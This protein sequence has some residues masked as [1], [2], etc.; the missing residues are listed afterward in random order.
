MSKKRS[1]LLYFDNFRRV[2]DLPDEQLGILLR[3]LME[4]GEKEANGE[5]G[6]TGLRDRYPELCEK[7]Q[8]A[9]SFMADTIRR[10]AA[11]YAEK[12]ANYRAAAQHRWDLQRE[13]QAIP[14]SPPADELE[15]LVRQ[16]RE[17]TGRP[18]WATL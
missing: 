6:I 12:C 1:I 7:A 13:S 8:M 10:D 17:K 5:D 18:D 15:R 11:S 4:F 2:A 3:A 14:D 9:F 16:Q